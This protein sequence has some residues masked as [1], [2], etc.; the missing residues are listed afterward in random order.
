VSTAFRIVLI[1]AAA[2]IVIALLLGPAWRGSFYQSWL[3]PRL[4]ALGLIIVLVGAGE[5][6]YRVVTAIKSR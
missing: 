6:V 2:A 4:I 1:V 3:R 5:Y